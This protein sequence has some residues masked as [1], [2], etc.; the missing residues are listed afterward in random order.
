MMARD[1]TGGMIPLSSMFAAT[2]A[3]LIVEITAYFYGL[4]TP[5]SGQMQSRK[6]EIRTVSGQV[7]RAGRSDT[8][9]GG[10]V[11]QSGS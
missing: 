11:Y 10:W 2:A 6:M 5:E 3:M 8:V 4:Y 9:P 7:L 1:Y